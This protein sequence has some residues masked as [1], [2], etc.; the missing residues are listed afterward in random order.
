MRA[1]VKTLKVLAEPMNVVILR[2]MAHGPK[3][4]SDIAGEPGD[5]KLYDLSDCGWE[6][7]FVSAVLEFWLSRRPGGDISRDHREWERATEALAEGWEIGIVQS[8]AAAPR[9]IG[10]LH[11]EAG[12][13]V[14]PILERHVEQMVLAG[15]LETS[16]EAGDGETTYEATRWLCEAVGPLLA[17]ASAEYSY[18][19]DGMQPIA[20]EDAEAIFIL[21]L[22]PLEL[23]ESL[24]GSCWLAM[25]L[26]EDGQLVQAG[27]LADFDAGMLVAWRPGADAGA[28]ADSEVTGDVEAW[29]SALIDGDFGPLKIGGEKA[30]SNAVL[31]CMHHE[32]FARLAG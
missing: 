10:E 24:A 30:I 5:E 18:P 3:S 6:Q 31:E 12:T 20:R 25:E 17:A 23:D 9:T 1:G 15:L 8:L 7:V 28:D 2:E 19:S 11:A 26:P 14:R 27:V 21:A 13:V 4:P 32:L 16:G 22:M 29:F